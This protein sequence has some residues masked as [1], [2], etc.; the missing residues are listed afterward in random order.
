MKNK[1]NISIALVAFIILVAAQSYVISA[2]Y[3][4]KNEAFSRFYG[5]AILNGLETYQQQKQL[6]PLGQVFKVMDNLASRLV[7]DLPEFELETDSVK[8]KTSRLFAEI[9]T[10][11]DS[12]TPFLKKHLGLKEVDNDI[13][14]FFIVRDLKLVDF[15][16]QFSICT[17][18]SRVAPARS[19]G[20]IF[21]QSFTAKYNNFETR[22]DFYVDF[23][24]RTRIIVHEMRSLIFVLS[25]T[26]AVVMLVYILTLRSMFR[27]K[28]LSELKSDFISNMTHELKTPLSTISV[29]SASLSLD[30]VVGNPEKSKYLSDIIKRQNK[31]LNRMI[32]QVLDIS[33]LE[34]SGFAINREPTNFKQFLTEVAEDFRLNLEDKKS[35][36]DVD[37]NIDDGFSIWLDRFQMIR[38][39]NNLFS[40]A[41]KYNDKKPEIKVIVSLKGNFLNVAVSDNGIGIS[42]ENQ[43]E[44]FEKFF[45]CENNLAQKTKGLGLGLYFVKKIVET[46]NGEVALESKPGKG[47]TF[48][49]SIPINLKNNENIVG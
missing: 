26:V 36:I 30:E 5:N 19:P 21:I 34:R 27:Q 8:A 17:D 37:F 10:K 46:H 14:T 1:L 15:V 23:S 48:F 42:K 29:A 2:F 4:E 25:L 20:A 3:Q 7:Y 38:V 45:R 11:N 49:I 39:F 18:T 33:A 24:H 35:A 28:K 32:D 41:V 22:I 6:N 13:Q 12:I 16:R 43:K 31:L 44:V 9:I 47:S 40:N